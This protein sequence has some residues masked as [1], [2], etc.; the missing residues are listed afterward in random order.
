MDAENFDAAGEA[1]ERA[2]QEH[3]RPGKARHRKSRVSRGAAGSSGDADGEAKRRPP[4][5]NGERGSCDQRDHES[6][7]RVEARQFPEPCARRHD[8]RLQEPGAGLAERP[9]QRLLDEQHADEIQEERDEH[10]VHPPPEM[11]GRCNSGPQCAERG[12]S[13]QGSGRDEPGRERRPVKRNRRRA[14][15]TERDLALGADVDDPSAEAEG[16]S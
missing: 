16:D 2:G 13:D 15:P 1:S 11:D 4:Q 3:G 8:R 12:R 14:E 5:R 7:M 10:L 6:D 9:R